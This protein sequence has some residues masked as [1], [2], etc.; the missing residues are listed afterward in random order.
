MAAQIPGIAGRCYP[1]ALP[2]ALSG[3]DPNQGRGRAREHHPSP[4]RGSAVFSYSDV[5][6]GHVDDVASRLL[7][8][9]ARFALF[10]RAHHAVSRRSVVAVWAGGQDAAKVLSAAAWR[11]APREGARVAVVDI[12]CRMAISSLPVCSGSRPSR[13]SLRPTSPSRSA[14]NTSRTWR[15]ER[16]VR[17]RGLWGILVRAE[18]EADVIVWD[19]G[20]NDLPF[21]RP[22]LHFCLVDRIARA[23]IQLSP[24]R[25]ESPH[26][27]CRCDHQGGHAPAGSI[28]AVRAAA[29]ALAPARADRRHAPADHGGRRHRRARAPRARGDDGPTPR[30]ADVGR[31]G[32]ACR[33]CPGAMLVDPGRMRMEHP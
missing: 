8:S 15:Q 29:R 10:R 7:A 28:V 19:G 11:R 26:G 3:R 18:A 5:S 6:H 16:R 14:R 33:R 9:G 12:R 24:R 31:R 32:R 17:G 21:Y 25:D 22:T 13:I 23:T 2:S 20:N 30:M 27:G 4:T 1:A